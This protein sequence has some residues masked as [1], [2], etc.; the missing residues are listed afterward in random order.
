MRV[1]LIIWLTDRFDCPTIGLVEFFHSEQKGGNPIMED[2]NDNKSL[3]NSIIDSDPFLRNFCASS[4]PII[5]AATKE[6]NERF[7]NAIIKI[8]K[9]E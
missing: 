3:F 6:E 5:E 8:G 9:G 1:R 2:S 7:V 4:R